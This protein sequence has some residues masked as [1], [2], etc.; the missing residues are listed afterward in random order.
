MSDIVERLEAGIL[1]RSHGDLARTA[2]DEIVRL[3]EQNAIAR[4]WMDR[5]SVAELLVH[6]AAI[7]TAE[8]RAERDRLRDALTLY[9]EAVVI[10]V[11]MEGPRFMGA[12]S[13]ALKRAWDHDRAALGDK[14]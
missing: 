6:E 14:P 3:R 8:L 10:D 1:S 9:R 4:H 13:S 7:T 5:A 12:N 2:R 11:K